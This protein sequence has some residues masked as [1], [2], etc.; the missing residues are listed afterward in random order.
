MQTVSNLSE[1]AIQKIKQYHYDRI[2]EKHEGPW[3]WE[4][5]I[6]YG[7][8]IFVRAD[9]VDVLLPL[10]EK[11]LPNITVL[12]CV[13]SQ[14]NLCL[15]LFLK[16]TTWYGDDW[17]AAGFIAFAEKVAGENF[18]ITTV[19]HEWFILNERK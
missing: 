18:Y 3:S 8:G 10:D 7:D 19:Y 1:G 17:S 13:P 11:H 12:R 14:D 15:T 16:D 9:G 5:E 2:V 6:K 4:N